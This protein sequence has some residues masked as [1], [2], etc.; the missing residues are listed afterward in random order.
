M[1]YFAIN[2][3][4]HAVL[5]VSGTHSSYTLPSVPFLLSFLFPQNE[6]LYSVFYSFIYLWLHWVF[7]ATCRLS[8]VAVQALGTWAS[9]VAAQGLVACGSRALECAGFSNCGMWAQLLLGTQN[10]PN[11]GSNPCPLHWQ[12]DS[13]LKFLAILI[14]KKNKI[15]LTLHWHFPIS[16]QAEYIFIFINRLYFLGEFLLIIPIYLFMC[17]NHIAILKG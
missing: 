17:V 8:L 10:L 11:Q 1:Q 3:S 4:R 6:I 12:V 7:A 13:Y 15:K 16:N 2:C 5:Q 9:L 14:G